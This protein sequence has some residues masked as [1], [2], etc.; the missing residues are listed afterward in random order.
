MNKR[1]YFV[2]LKTLGNGLAIYLNKDMLRH[3]R[4]CKDSDICLTLNKNRSIT[5]SKASY[6]DNYIEEIVAKLNDLF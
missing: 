1:K 4:I 6:S 2:K 3:L 5:V